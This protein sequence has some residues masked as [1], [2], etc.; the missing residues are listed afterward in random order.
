MLA[1]EN[2]EVGR[3]R[4]H[5]KV[6]HPLPVISSAVLRSLIRS[7]LTAGLAEKGAEEQL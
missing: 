3:E 6:T 2:K 4:G 1:S 5:T 7:S